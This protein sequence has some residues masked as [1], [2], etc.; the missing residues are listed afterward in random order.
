MHNIPMPLRQPWLRLPEETGQQ[1]EAFERYRDLGPS[2]SIDLIVKQLAPARALLDGSDPEHRQ[3]LRNTARSG[4][5]DTDTPFGYQVLTWS[6]RF[7]WTF[8]AEQFDR[9]IAQMASEKIATEHAQMLQRHIAI[10]MQLQEKALTRLRTMD[11]SELSSK[12]VLA[13]LKEAVELERVSRD[14]P[15]PSLNRTGEITVIDPEASDRKVLNDVFSILVESGAL[16]EG[17][18]FDMA[19]GVIDAK[20]HEIYSAQSDDET[21]SVP[22]DS[23]S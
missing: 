18:D 21:D 17:A 1:Y 10:S 4:Q 20:A 8:R 7:R 13:Y 23:T 3:V 15:R 9:H 16:P 6:N 5:M 19:E 2:R 11:S 14:M 12:E 22:V